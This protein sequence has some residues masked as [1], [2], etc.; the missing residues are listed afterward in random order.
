MPLIIG[1]CHC[2]NISYELLLPVD[3]T[4]AARSCSCSFCSKQN[5]TYTAHKD[6]VLKAIF[7]SESLVNRY[8]FG[9][10]TAQ[11]IVCSQCGILPFVISTIDQS[12]YAVVNVNTFE[13]KQSWQIISSKISFDEESLKERLERRKKTWIP[14]VNIT[15]LNRN[16]V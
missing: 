5:A 3:K 1:S 11:F 9:M 14:T 15:I 12:T 8:T 16:D 6:A 13:R 4:I 7:K 10:N 2:K